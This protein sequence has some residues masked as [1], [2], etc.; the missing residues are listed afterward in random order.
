MSATPTRNIYLFEGPIVFVAKLLTGCFFL[1]T[2][3]F[4]NSKLFLL[5]G[6]I[7]IQ[8]FLLDND[9]AVVPPLQHNGLVR[10]GHLVAAVLHVALGGLL[11]DAAPQA[12]LAALPVQLLERVIESVLLERFQVPELHSA[13]VAGEELVGRKTSPVVLLPVLDVS[14]TVPVALAALLADERLLHGVERADVLQGSVLLQQPDRGEGGHARW[15]AEHLL[16]EE[17]RVDEAHL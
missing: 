6:T 1:V 16:A 9:G 8:V 2:K 4:Q 3:T 14:R 5:T 17:R 11:A 15:T 12:R 13:D 10:A 7:V